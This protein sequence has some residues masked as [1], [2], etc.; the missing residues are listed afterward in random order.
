[1]QRWFLIL[2]LMGLL[3]LAGAQKPDRFQLSIHGEGNPG[4][5]E[6]FVQPVVLRNGGR[7]ATL[8]RLPLVTE[9]D[10]ARFYPFQA[11]DG[12]QGTY[13]Q[14]RPHATKLVEQFTMTQKGKAIV[15]FANGRQVIDLV[16]TK[17]IRDGIITIPGGLMPT[18]IAQLASR[19]DVIGEPADINRLR[20]KQ[21]TKLLRGETDL[22]EE[23]EKIDQARQQIEQQ[24]IPKAEPVNQP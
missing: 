7:E 13:L 6:K 17:P 21:A 2:P 9:S 3:C 11:A 19:F 18:E 24:N 8:S 4:D 23:Q 20:K 16:V 10:I 1:M 12:S 5:G 14:L 22:S 15:V